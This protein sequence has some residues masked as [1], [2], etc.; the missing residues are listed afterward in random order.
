MRASPRLA[1]AHEIWTSRE[2][3]QR[4]WETSAAALV[5]IQRA[6]AESE[7]R[8]PAAREFLRLYDW[9][10]ARDPDLF[11]AC[12][13]APVALPWVRRCYDAL[14]RALAG[15]APAEELDAWLAHWKALVLGMAVLGGETLAFDAPYAVEL[16][17]SV[18]GTGR[19]LPGS[20]SAL[21]HGTREGVP[22]L[23]AGPAEL[24]AAPRV[25]LAGCSL[26]LDPFALRGLGADFPEVRPALAAGLEFQAE[27][28]EL[29]ARALEALRR[30]AP[31][32]FELFAAGIRC[33]ALKPARDDD[34]TSNVTVNE[35]AGAFVAL[36]IAEPLDLADT[37]V[38]ELHHNRLFCLEDEAQLLEDEQDVAHEPSPHYSPWREDPRPVRGILHAV[39]VTVPVTRYWL[40]ALASGELAGPLADYA[41]DRARRS[42]LQTAIGSEQLARLARFTAAGKALFEVLAQS[43]A[44]LRE[45][46]DAAGVPADPPAC[47]CTVGGEVKPERAAPDGPQ[48]GVRAALLAHIEKFDLAREAS[49]PD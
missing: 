20:G 45:A 7:H 47:Y 23:A 44:E 31:D 2:P 36:R 28:R 32:L 48:V 17:F 14:G 33:V 40:R 9:A 10:A 30:H 12:W 11:T 19:T 24:A 42:Q 26:L 18:P 35:L 25:E 1:L 16:P 8:T 21:L 39:Y 6:L 49:L 29:V 4:R 13:E 46:I 43:A 27:S 41:R 38:H 3:A 22:L 15:E 5:A 34:P 37:F